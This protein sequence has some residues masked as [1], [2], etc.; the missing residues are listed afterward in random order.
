MEEEIKLNKREEHSGDI[1]KELK[2]L[3]KLEDTNKMVENETTYGS[4]FATL[5]CC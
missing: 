5:L 3:E 4:S 1:L 2:E